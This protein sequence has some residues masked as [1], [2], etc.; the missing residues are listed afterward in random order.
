MK[1][2]IIGCGRVGS[3]LA[4]RLATQE[5][6]V[7]IVDNTREAF[8]RLGPSFGGKSDGCIDRSPCRFRK[9]L[10]ESSVTPG[11]GVGARREN[12]RPGPC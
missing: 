6:Q 5:H 11:D 9:S 12:E 7:A 2:L 4:R 3:R 10:S 1:I 8:L